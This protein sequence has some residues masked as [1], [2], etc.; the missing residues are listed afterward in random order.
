MLLLVGWQY[1]Y[2]GDLWAPMMFMLGGLR[3][4]GYREIGKVTLG[5]LRVRP[6]QIRVLRVEKRE[7][8][9]TGTVCVH[10]H[11]TLTNQQNTITINQ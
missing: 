9:R 6:D 10:T 4:R 8:L 7:R 2:A 11:F 1:L 5:A 3:L